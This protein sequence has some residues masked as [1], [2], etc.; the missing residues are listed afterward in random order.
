MS[1]PEL[2][3]ADYST[4]PLLEDEEGQI[5]LCIAIAHASRLV[6]MHFG[7]NQHQ[8]IE[9]VVTPDGK[10]HVVQTRPQA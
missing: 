3:A 1:A 9:G 7:H 10:I 4:D 6:A 5:R 2:V 8:D